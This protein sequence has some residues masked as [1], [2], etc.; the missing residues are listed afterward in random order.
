[1]ATGKQPTPSPRDRELGLI[2]DELEEMNHEARRRHIWIRTKWNL[3]N[4]SPWHLGS[5]AAPPPG[6][7][8]LPVEYVRAEPHLWKWTDIEN[9]LMTLVRLCPL[10]LTE[11]QSVLLTNPA[12]GLTGV[13]VTNTMRI[14]ISIYKQ[15]DIAQSHMHSPNASRT[16]LSESGG[17]TV[18]EGERIAPR[19]GDLVFTPNG[20]WHEH[21]NLDADPVIWV[22]TLDWPFLDFLG[23]AWSRTD[24]GNAPQ[25]PAVAKD[26]SSRFFGHGGIKPLFA[27]YRRGEGRKVTTM[28]LHTGA[29]IRA[30][31]DE[32]RGHDG[33]PH[34]GVIVEIV[35]PATG[36]PVFSTLSYRAQLL[37][38]G[39]TTAP[40][41]HT[42]STIYCVID[43]SGETDIDG[44]LYHWDRNDFFVVP[45]HRWRHFRNTGK[46]DA[47]LY[48]TTDAPLVEKIGYY[49][50]QGKTKSGAVVDLA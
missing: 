23:A 20:T 36:G 35:D 7:H 9:Y 34:D 24:P 14:A 45:N 42:A 32:L 17:Y 5:S 50:A 26:F 6:P 11:R 31:L 10:E 3:A 39:E 13:K 33:D 46:T 47:V 2:I 41:R 28:F 19:R 40:F 29:D 25:Q 8:N 30:Q 44:T 1:M 21:G 12:Y 48:S 15:G 16:I 18:V 4:Q 38:P 27:P 43:G 37:R 22:D 49:R